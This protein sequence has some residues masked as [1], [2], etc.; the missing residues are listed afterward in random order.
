MVTIGAM[1]N[2]P[3]PMAIMMD[4]MLVVMVEK[5]VVKIVE[6]TVEKMVVE[7]TMGNLW[8]HPAN[9]PGLR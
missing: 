8:K 9:T 1:T 2:L 3:L 7:M 5:M 6:M 4:M